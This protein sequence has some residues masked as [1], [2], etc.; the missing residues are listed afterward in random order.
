[1]NQH[2]YIFTIGP[3]QSFI[4]QA[5]KAQDLYAGSQILSEL[6]RKGVAFFE[7]EVK[8]KGNEVS[9]IFPSNW[10]DDNA[11]LPNRFI[12]KIE[13]S[14]EDTS[15]LK[16][17]GDAT[18]I[19]IE[20]AFNNIAKNT[21]GRHYSSEV[22]EQ[23]KRHLE[24]HWAALP[25]KGD[26]KSTYLKL[27]SLLGA[28]KNIRPFAQLNDGNGEMGRKCS[29]DGENNALFFHQSTLQ[30][31]PCGQSLLAFCARKALAY[32]YGLK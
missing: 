18:K 17:L 5:R 3:V 24:V 19:A 14:E 7:T 16:N 30:F 26:Y 2:L 1:M 4:A 10:E 25:I 12:A 27:E 21:L 13:S 29:L 8:K 28:V 6:V 15:N 32:A 23:I 11:S 22:A 20:D 9:I 31:A